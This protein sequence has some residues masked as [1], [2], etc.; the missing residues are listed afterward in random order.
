[1]DI[2]TERDSETYV[3]L[4]IYV[5]I[6]T[7]IY[8]CVPAQL[9]NSGCFHTLWGGVRFRTKRGFMGMV[10]R[11]PS[12]SEPFVSNPSSTMSRLCAQHSRNLNVAHL[13]GKRSMLRVDT[14]ASLQHFRKLGRRLTTAVHRSM[15]TGNS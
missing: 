8:R 12:S 4:H 9:C 1:M 5:Y 7:C 2:C 15:A 10:G 11:C 3:Y 6:Y 13:V 14:S